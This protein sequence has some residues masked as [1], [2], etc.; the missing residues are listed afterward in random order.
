MADESHLSLLIRGAN[1]WN[2]W[3]HEHRRDQADLSE[4]DLRRS[5]LAGADLRVADLGRADL[6]GAELRRANLSRADLSMAYLIGANLSEAILTGAI[7]RNACLDGVNFERTTV[8]RTIFA[9]VDL[10]SC[11]G[12]EAVKHEGPCELGVGS[13]IH[14]KGRIP[15]IFL[16]GVSLPD[17][18]IDYIPSLVGDGIQFFSCFISYSS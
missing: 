14:S 2:E 3:R 4:A 13:I 5:N 16:R 1:A 8:S 11:K 10:S 17:E 18:W 12:L 6:S 9:S 15:E 7:L